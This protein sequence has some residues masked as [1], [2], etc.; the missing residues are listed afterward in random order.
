[1]ASI[2][3]LS[4][5][6][7]Q[8]NTI[9]N[10]IVQL[11]EIPNTAIRLNIL[12]DSRTEF[13]P[14][15]LII[16]DNL[17]HKVEV[18]LKIDIGDTTLN[19][20]TTLHFIAS[21]GSLIE[22]IIHTFYFFPSPTPNFIFSPTDLTFMIL[23]NV[24]KTYSLKTTTFP[25]SNVYITINTTCT[26]SYSI[27][28]NTGTLLANNNELK[29]QVSPL[30]N[31]FEGNC[32]VNHYIITED[33]DYSRFN[34]ITYNIQTIN[35]DTTLAPQLLDAIESNKENIILISFDRKCYLRNDSIVLYKKFNCSDIFTL[36]SDS[37][38]VSYCRWLNDRE[39][40]LYYNEFDTTVSIDHIIAVKPKKIYGNELSIYYSTG[41]AI[42][43]L[44]KIPPKLLNGKYS[45]DL[46]S[47]LISYDDSNVN[48]YIGY[49]L[50]INGRKCSEI[51]QEKELLGS[52]YCYLDNINKYI[53]IELSLDSEIIIPLHISNSECVIDQSLTL[54]NNTIKP[55]KDSIYFMS[56]CINIYEPA[57]TPTITA[58]IKQYP[59]SDQISYCQDIVLDASVS[60]VN[61][62]MNGKILTYK[63]DVS[64]IDNNILTN[65]RDLYTYVTKQKESVIKISSDLINQELINTE[66]NSSFSFTVTVSSVILPQ[67]R[68]TYN[69]VISIIDDVVNPIIESDYNNK[70]YMKYY[71]DRYIKGKAVYESCNNNNNNNKIIFRYKWK[72]E[73]FNGDVLAIDS[74]LT[75][76]PTK[77][78]IKS[79]SLVVGKYIIK[80]QTT[81]LINNIITDSE[82]TSITLH[83]ESD[84]TATL[85]INSNIKQS[86]IQS[87]ND[88][89]SIIL[90]VIDEG[91]KDNNHFKY[92]WSCI[93][94]KFEKCKEQNEDLDII[95]LD[96]LLNNRKSLYL[97]N[98]R[99][100][101]SEYIFTIEV[102]GLIT[103]R[104]SKIMI[105]VTVTDY[106]IVNEIETVYHLSTNSFFISPSAYKQTDIIKLKSELEK[107][108]NDNN[109]NE[110]NNISFEWKYFNDNK[111]NALISR[112]DTHIVYFDCKE[113]NQKVTMHLI[114][115]NIYIHNDTDIDIISQYYPFFIISQKPTNGYL[116]STDTQIRFGDNILISTSG[117]RGAEPF[118]YRFGVILESI[119]EEVEIIEEDEEDIIYLQTEYSNSNEYSGILP[120]GYK[121]NN[122]YVNI[123]VCVK[124]KYDQTGC[125][126]Y[127]NKG[128]ILTVKV[129]PVI[130]IDD[131][132]DK[133]VILS[134]YKDYDEMIN[135]I[136]GFSIQI[137]MPQTPVVECSSNGV[138]INC[139]CVCNDGY[140]GRLCEKHIPI[141][142]GLNNE[143]KYSNWS[144]NC[145]LIMRYK[146]RECDNPKPQYGGNTCDFAIEIETK[147]LDPCDDD[148]I[149]AIYTEW[150]NWSE[151]DAYCNIYNGK[152]AE[153]FQYRT[154]ECIG[155]KLVCEKEEIV[156]TKKCFIEC[157]EVDKLCPGQL[158]D[159]NGE[160]VGTSCSNRGKC[161]TNKDNCGEFEPNCHSWCKCDD[162]YAG[163]E[164]QYTT[165][166]YDNIIIE[167]EYIFDNIFKYVIGNEVHESVN[168]YEQQEVIVYYLLNNNY[169]QNIGEDHINSM[170]NLLQTQINQMKVK[171]YNKIPF[172]IFKSLTNIAS[173]LIDFEW[174]KINVRKEINQE[175]KIG[176]QLKQY[177]IDISVIHFN[178]QYYNEIVIN[179]NIISIYLSKADIGYKKLHNSIGL[180]D[181][182][183]DVYDRLDLS[184]ITEVLAIYWNDQYFFIKTEIPSSVLTIILN[185]EINSN[186]HNLYIPLNPVDSNKIYYEQRVSRDYEE[187]V[188][189]K[190]SY[191]NSNNEIIST[192]TLLVGIIDEEL[193][194]TRYAI[195]M[196]FNAADFIFTATEIDGN[197]HTVCPIKISDMTGE[198]NKNNYYVLIPLLI[199]IVVIIICALLAFRKDQEEID[200]TEYISEKRIKENGTLSIYTEIEYEPYDNIRD[201]I[202]TIIIN[203]I[204]SCHSILAPI[205]KK[206]R[207][208][209]T[210]DRLQHVLIIA[211][212]ISTLF[213]VVSLFYSDVDL[214]DEPTA[215]ICTCAAILIPVNI[216][217]PL[218]YYECRNYVTSSVKHIKTATSS[219]WQTIKRVFN[220][221]RWSNYSE[222]VNE[223]GDNENDDNNT[224]VDSR[225]TD[226]FYISIKSIPNN[227]QPTI[228]KNPF[229]NMKMYLYSTSGVFFIFT[230]IFFIIFAVIFN[231]GTPY[232]CMY[233][234]TCVFLLE[235]TFTF[236]STFKVFFIYYVYCLMINLFLLALDIFFIVLYIEE[237]TKGGMT[238]SIWELIYDNGLFKGFT[239]YSEKNLQ[240]CGYSNEYKLSLEKCSVNSIRCK[241]PL[242]DVF[243]QYAPLWLIYFFIL[244]IIIFIRIV[245]ILKIM[246]FKHSSIGVLNVGVINIDVFNTDQT[247]AASDIIVYLKYAVAKKKKRRL[248]ESLCIYKYFIILLYIFIDFK[249]TFEKRRIIMG[250]MDLALILYIILMLFISFSYGLKF[251]TKHLNLWLISVTSSYALHILIQ[252]P[253]I[254]MC[255]TV[256]RTVLTSYI[257]K[258]NTNF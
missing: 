219:L 37:L 221:Y 3:E 90:N 25:S 72:I 170:F 116:Y 105:S 21:D 242:H 4:T 203:K 231:I 143:Y 94:S 120:T 257:S 134:N 119:N 64:E 104:K 179:T 176:K 207:D 8:D 235:I 248:K 168:L 181:N 46:S 178:Q 138:L 49:G 117:W 15:F 129:N 101:V 55:T 47:I 135:L 188:K 238:G 128:N 149:T 251:S 83:V 109:N 226:R 148:N 154:R 194:S 26:D 184:K 85:K 70:I 241:E 199:I 123:I 141:D 222:I 27:A 103:S 150:S 28:P 39:I 78:L 24:T 79:N 93:T 98:T 246:F 216:I 108:E 161:Y 196:A 121:H 36:T 62:K 99:L 236:Y 9:Q 18:K 67:Y 144:S 174:Y 139:I 167:N 166:E 158:I 218:L 205:L 130:N 151:C 232:V 97:T 164:C 206:S 191:I 81:A 52:S 189:I 142:G 192:G 77:L 147:V 84:E 253:I 245:L 118:S 86:T 175:Y 171:K 13:N 159:D 51:F 71:E 92:E 102:T 208:L 2:A 1:M 193:N 211:A 146:Y 156:E 7:T 89:I 12:G 217:V 48:S 163:K 34:R 160:I 202:S 69:V 87:I 10:L 172:N 127:N 213:A 165:I 244:A 65:Y 19:I 201:T 169:I 136:V 32:T 247:Q 173:N 186:N 200:N 197:I 57:N 74:F 185:S 153:G 96:L 42:I 112:N 252:Q 177:F 33:R 35:N 29:I 162:G 122:Y 56:G 227:N 243:V 254:I 110:N 61:N 228:D 22:E 240:C 58:L 111:E 115:L 132:K 106:D 80:L 11:K 82:T 220:I 180:S 17:Q 230:S 44:R 30:P 225:A 234:A 195:C 204:K 182:S 63:W 212:E 229:Y 100:L 38:D 250:L 20:Q 5:E 113:L 237:L 258:K 124:D 133:A 23:D 53:V 66:Y 256:I 91:N 45:D 107:E 145:G 95:P 239:S 6:N 223:K 68:S 137:S 14:P 152:K 126:Y 59:S 16:I 198:Y 155:S 125:S 157:S 249:K 31:R 114:K 255:Y 54:I 224:S 41:S 215:I 73:S 131:I 187:N 75:N 60:L 76:D 214:L 140:T 190:C 210:I 209:V 50:D 233:I 183:I 40:I 88:P 43:Q